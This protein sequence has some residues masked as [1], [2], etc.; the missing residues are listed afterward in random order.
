M[1][2]AAARVPGDLAEYLDPARSPL[3]PR[4]LGFDQY[5]YGSLP[6]T[7]GKLVAAS[8]GRE[9]PQAIAAAGRALAAGLDG[10]AS[11]TRSP[12]SRSSKPT[13]S[14]STRS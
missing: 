12:C 10:P 3:A 2:A 8:L 6:L 9:D 4:N 5:V 1:V 13:S 7:L 14:P 11:P